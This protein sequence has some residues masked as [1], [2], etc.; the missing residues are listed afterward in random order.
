MQ[1]LCFH[2][3][4]GYRDNIAHQRNSSAMAQSPDWKKETVDPGSV[5]YVAYPQRPQ[6][7]AHHLA[8]SNSQPHICFVISQVWRTCLWKRLARQRRR[9][10][11]I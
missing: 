2:V 4:C 10:S 5:P 3:L 6:L 9:L 8:R 7:E 11:T 1:R